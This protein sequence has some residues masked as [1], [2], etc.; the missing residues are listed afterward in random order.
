MLVL[1]DSKDKFMIRIFDDNLINY[2]DYV[3]TC[4]QNLCSLQSFDEV[5]NLLN[6]YFEEYK[7]PK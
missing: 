6:Q 5:V 4:D 3:I 7:C 1:E 2:E